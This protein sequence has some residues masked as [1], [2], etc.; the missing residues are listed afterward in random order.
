VLP[1]DGGD[2]LQEGDNVEGS[3]LRACGFAI[4]EKIEELEAYRVTLVV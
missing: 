4:K 2:E 3:V 1:E